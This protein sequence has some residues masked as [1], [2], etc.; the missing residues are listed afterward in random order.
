[1]TT[2]SRAAVA[3]FAARYAFFDAAVFQL[4]ST[5]TMT[6]GVAPMTDSQLNG[7]HDSAT[8]PAL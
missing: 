5:R 8:V 3:G 7:V 6:S 2:A 1:M 4:A